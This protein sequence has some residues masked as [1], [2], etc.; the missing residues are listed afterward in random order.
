MILNDSKNV[1]LTNTDTDT[2]TNNDT[3]FGSK[4]TYIPNLN[5]FLKSWYIN[6][7]HNEKLSNAY[8]KN[9][10]QYITVDNNFVS[11]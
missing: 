8:N 6:Y 5:L 4:K 1:N 9:V 3:D 11:I 7:A 10:S 2:N